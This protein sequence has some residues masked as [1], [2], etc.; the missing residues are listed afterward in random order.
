MVNSFPTTIQ[1]LKPPK[2]FPLSLSTHSARIL[3]SDGLV[4][5]PNGD[6]SHELNLKWIVSVTL[7]PA[8]PPLSHNV[9]STARGAYGTPR[10]A[11]RAASDR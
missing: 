8:C 6:S 5:V 10:P 3:S 11:A 7:S 1:Y 2:D 4:L 9:G